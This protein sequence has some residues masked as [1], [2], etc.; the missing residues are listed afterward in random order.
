MRDDEKKDHGGTRLTAGD[1]VSVSVPAPKLSH[2]DHEFVPFWI[3]DP[4]YY[5]DICSVCGDI[6]EPEKAE[7]ASR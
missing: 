2:A 5:A 7:G 6:H 3:D 4:R 1:A